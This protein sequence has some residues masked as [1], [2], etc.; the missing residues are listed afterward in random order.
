[1]ENTGFAAAHC[2]E[3]LALR[4]HVYKLSGEAFGLAA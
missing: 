1:M 2:G 3:P 4:T